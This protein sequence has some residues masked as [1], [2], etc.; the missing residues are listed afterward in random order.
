[1]LKCRCALNLNSH[2]NFSVRHPGIIWPIGDAKPIWAEGSTNTTRAK[3]GIFRV[4]Y[5]ALCLLTSIDH[6]HNHAPCS[7]VQYPLEPLDTIGRDA[8]DGGTGSG[9]GNG[10]NHISH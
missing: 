4:L 3:W 1:M 8:H 9:I 2:D 10:C 5:Y 7:G 6:W